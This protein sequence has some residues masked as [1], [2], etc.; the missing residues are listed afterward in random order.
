MPNC[1]NCQQF[2]PFNVSINGKNKNLSK[3]KFCLTC[4]PFGENNRRSSL[5]VQKC[6]ICECELNDDNAYRKKR[7]FHSQCKKC[8]LIH[9]KI[10]LQKFKLIAIA[11]KGGCCQECGY[12]K[13]PAALDFHH[14]LGKDKLFKISGG[15]LTKLTERAKI[16]LDKCDLLCANC[17]R[18]KHFTNLIES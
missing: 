17:H 18:E 2:F 1:R 4:S 11:Y 3:R 14:R 9:H 7:T 5:Q 16:E 8:H 12:N 15:K 13:C 6:T 10:R